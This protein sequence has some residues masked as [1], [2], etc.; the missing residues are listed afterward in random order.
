MYHTYFV[1][2]IHVVYGIWPILYTPYC[3]CILFIDCLH[4]AQSPDWW[5]DV[6]CN[7]AIINDEI[8]NENTD[9]GNG[10]KMSKRYAHRI[11]SN[12]KIKKESVANWVGSRFSVTFECIIQYGAWIIIIVCWCIQ[13]NLTLNHLPFLMSSTISISVK[14]PWSVMLDT[15]DNWHAVKWK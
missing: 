4:S 1:P 5:I 14:H 10:C 15:I 6:I 11:F 9:N 13:L 2:K 12:N 8:S 7:R 3:I